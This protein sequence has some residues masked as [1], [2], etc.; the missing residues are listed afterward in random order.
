MTS[1]SI[2]RLTSS[3]NQDEVTEARVETFLAGAA[4]CAL[5]NT[6]VEREDIVDLDNAETT[7]AEA[8]WWHSKDLGW[9]VGAFNADGQAQLRAR[10]EAFVMANM[11][12][13]GAL[14]T[15]IEARREDLWGD[16]TGY[17]WYRA[18]MLF[19]YAANGAGLGFFDYKYRGGAMDA[20]ERLQQ[21][22]ERGL[23]GFLCGITAWCY[24]AEHS[25]GGAGSGAAFACR[26][27]S[28][29]H[30]PVDLVVAAAAQD[31]GRV[32][33]FLSTRMV[34]AVGRSDHA[35]RAV[36]SVKSDLTGSDSD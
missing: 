30:E 28:A 3:M 19:T 14:T 16:S 17:A 22:A 15:E 20:A 33:D 6:R 10:V 35:R 36:L 24:D 18:G 26:A 11:A 29:E 8:E 23:D 27:S 31:C 4:R 1:Y 34:W 7:Y 21:A 32:R 9:E 13:L 12:D 2:Y 25:D 5:G